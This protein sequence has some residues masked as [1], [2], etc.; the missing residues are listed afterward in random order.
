LIGRENDI[1]VADILSGTEH[2]IAEG[3]A[4]H[5]RIGVMGWSN[6]GYLTNCVLTARPELFAAASSGAGVLDMVIQWGVEDTPGHVINF[7]QGLPWEV[8]DHYRE[9]SPLY[10][11]DKVRTP[12]LI[13]VGGNDPRVP[14]AHSR[15]LYRALH[16]YLDVPC[17][18]V[19]YPDEPHGLTKRKNRLAKMK[20]DLAW[21]AMYL[22]VDE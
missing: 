12:T 15:A 20:W 9:A 7:A 2:L 11:L 1:E 8:P 10:E 16:H 17:E 18:L 6:G 5:G 21:L 13:H 19:V 3:I 14:P 22:P 4:A